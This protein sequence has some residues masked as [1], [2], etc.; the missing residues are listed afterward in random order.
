MNRRWVLGTRPTYRHKFFSVELSWV[1]QPTCNL[2][3]EGYGRPLQTRPYFS[4]RN[5]YTKEE[6]LEFKGEIR[7]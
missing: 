2:S 4:N 3:P 6:N 7:L 5:Y 1:G